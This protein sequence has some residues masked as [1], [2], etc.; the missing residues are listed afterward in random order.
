MQRQA[1]ELNLICNLYLYLCLSVW[2]SL[3]LSLSLKPVQPGSFA[4]NILVISQLVQS[5]FVYYSLRQ[6]EDPK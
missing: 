5:Q 4:E 6:R 3:S 1:L 2:L